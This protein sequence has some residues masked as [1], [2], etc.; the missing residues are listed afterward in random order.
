[1]DDDVAALVR[2]ERLNEA[3]AIAAE[4]GDARTAS[5]LYERA[6]A[7]SEEPRLR[8][9]CG[10]ATPARG[11]LLAAQAGDDALAQAATAALA[12]DRAAADATAARL[13]QRGLHRW[14]AAGCSR[15][16]RGATSR[17]R[18]RGSVRARRRAR[19]RCSKAAATRRGRRASWRAALRREPRRAGAIAAA[20]GAASRAAR[21]ATT[22]RCAS[23]SGSRGR[24]PGARPAALAHLARTLRAMGLG[25]AAADVASELWA[26]PAREPPAQTAPARRLLRP[27]RCDP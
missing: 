3:A 9:R 11:L 14:A 10:R 22:R 8:R 27:L 6:C 23:C 26:A 13:A 15:P 16:P 20:L 19:R 25:T 24:L 1:M 5:R 21:Q 12:K 4:R 7:W 17:R 2:Q 18:A